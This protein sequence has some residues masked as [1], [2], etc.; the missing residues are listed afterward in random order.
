MKKEIFISYCRADRTIVNPI[1]DEINSLLGFECWM[2]QT[3]IE[4]GTQFIDKIM[5]AIDESQIVLFMLSDNSVNS[6]WAQKEVLYAKKQGKKIIPIIIQGNGLRGWC[7]FIFVNVDYVVFSIEEHKNKLIKNLLKWLGLSDM[8]KTLHEIDSLLEEWKTGRVK[9]K[10]IEEDIRKKEESINNL[11]TKAS[12][13]I[14]SQ[15]NTHKNDELENMIK[16]YQD[17]EKKYQDLEKHYNDL[18]GK[19]T[20]PPS[21]TVQPIIKNPIFINRKFIDFYLVNNFWISVSVKNTD[22]PEKDLDFFNYKSKIKFRLPTSS[23]I[24]QVAKGTDAL[25]SKLKFGNI[26]WLQDG[27]QIILKD[28]LAEQSLDYGAGNLHLVVDKNDINL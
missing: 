10:L 1:V 7:E 17:L 15:E 18:L 20:T 27:E 19:N 25:K 13:W 21:P 23:E 6:V 16:A 26:L 11:N 24:Q 2:D 9:Q 12:E 8:E 4:S 22:D 3:D 14:S 5:K 28:Y